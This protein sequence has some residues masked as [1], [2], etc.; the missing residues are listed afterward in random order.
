MDGCNVQLKLITTEEVEKKPNLSSDDKGRKVLLPLHKMKQIIIDLSKLPVVMFSMHYVKSAFRDNGQIDSKNEVM[1]NEKALLGNY[2][3]KLVKQNL[4]KK[5][6]RKWIVI[7][8]A[9]S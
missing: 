4:M 9:K 7:A 5:E 8:Q 1:P 2:M 3:A 6:Y